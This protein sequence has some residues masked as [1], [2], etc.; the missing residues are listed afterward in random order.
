MKKVTEIITHPVVYTALHF[1]LSQ[2]AHCDVGNTVIFYHQRKIFTKQA[3]IEQLGY[4][5]WHLELTFVVLA[6][7]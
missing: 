4:E 3:D 5:N 1:S 2:S 6:V 7:P